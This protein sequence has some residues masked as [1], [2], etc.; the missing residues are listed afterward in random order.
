MKRNSLMRVFR[1]RR[2]LA[3]AVAAALILGLML[4]A[5]RVFPAYASGGPLGAIRSLAQMGIMP[6]TAASVTLS[7]NAYPPGV[8]LGVSGSGFGPSE[9]VDIFFDTTDL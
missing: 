6:R 9:G 4:T 2:V 3:G 7:E 8:P 5:M 1:S